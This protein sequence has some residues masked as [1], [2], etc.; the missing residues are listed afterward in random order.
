M[1]SHLSLFLDTKGSRTPLHKVLEATI[2]R[3]RRQTRA[4]RESEAAS[5]REK[6]RR[7]TSSG[8]RCKGVKGDNDD[9][10]GE[11]AILAMFQCF[12]P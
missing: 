4:A 5:R 6:M 2:W 7:K 10:E 12:N 1:L 8:R 3:H 9:D 11:D